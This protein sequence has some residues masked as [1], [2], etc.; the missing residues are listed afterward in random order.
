MADAAE[1]LYTGLT[2]AS[3]SLFPTGDETET[4]LWEDYDGLDKEVYVRAAELLAEQGVVF[5]DEEKP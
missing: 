1:M 3:R 2:Q 4:V 5:P